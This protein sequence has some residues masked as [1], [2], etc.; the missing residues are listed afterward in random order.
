METVITEAGAAVGAAAPAATAG[1]S[2]AIA[3]FVAA[4]DAR[5]FPPSAREQ[6][7]LSLLDWSAVAVA[8]A[9]EPVSRIV[10][11]MLAEEAGT[12]ES[13]VL[14]A[15]YK[16]PARAA[17]LANGTTAHAL[18]YDDTHFGFT[19][20]PSAPVIAAALA[21]AEK[22]GVGGAALLDAILVGA[23]AT[24][25]IGRWLGKAH[26]ER[27]FH[28]TA[29]SGSFGAAAAC[30]RLMGLD[31]ERVRHA[32]GIASTR[33]SG[34]KSQ[35]GTMGKPYHAG[36]AAANGVEAVSLAARG[37][38]SRPDGIE[39]KQGFAGTHD[40][41]GGDPRS[42]L[43]GLGREFQFE[44]VQYK[45]HACCHGTHA[46]LEALL[47]IRRQ[48][49]IAPAAVERVVITVHPQWLQVCNIA[50]PASGL[51]AKFSY[52]FTAALA[53]AGMDTGA[54]ATFADEICRR[55]DL[56][57][58]RDKV[59]VE[60]DPAMAEM[61][62]AIRLQTAAGTFTRAFDLESPAPQG[63]RDKL[64]AK[65]RSLLGPARASALWTAISDLENRPA[66][67]FVAVLA[68]AVTH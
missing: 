67:A 46:A 40:G 39:C 45:Y 31:E 26:Y 5:V 38:V 13:T 3:R 17:A 66:A 9:G 50:N 8:G 49:D 61:A 1:I 11:E 35:F 33:S 41:A 30:A 57:A 48:S 6:A 19:G 59:S 43:E 34:L 64:I 24:C 7:R 27:G 14:G 21:R 15:L 36:M 18:D 58:L 25:R 62:A 12:P 28:Q 63:Q 60:T 29:T 68:D 37:F 20:H 2:A 55:V 16:L 51:E 42:I 32:F 4:A 65:A 52:R 10:R 53:L 44:R 47:A 54:L 22:S 56:I 23:E